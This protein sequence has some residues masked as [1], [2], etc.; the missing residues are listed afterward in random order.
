MK[1]SCGKKF[2]VIYLFACKCD[3][4]SS[5][6]LFFFSSFFMNRSVNQNPCHQV[7]IYMHNVFCITE[8]EENRVEFKIWE[9]P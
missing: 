3:K 6:L 5:I 4:V 2:D 1:Q 9:V 7:S 8:N